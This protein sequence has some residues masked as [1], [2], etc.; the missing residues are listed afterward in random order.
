MNKST[1][2]ALLLLFL[3]ACSFNQAPAFK[4]NDTVMEGEAAEQF[5]HLYGSYKVVGEMEV[6]FGKVSA[7]KV[8]KENGKPVFRL[9]DKT[10]A[11]GLVISPRKCE[12]KIRPADATRFGVTCGA[13]DSLLGYALNTGVDPLILF[14]NQPGEK[15]R[16][17]NFLSADSTL[18]AR[19]GEY[20]LYVS[21]GH[22]HAQL[23]MNRVEPANPGNLSQ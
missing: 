1:T 12:A 10:G 18:V 14:N 21:Y 19:D 16:L 9:Y 17:Q 2:A 8:S 22:S 11:E 4:R 6:S 7:V 3:S 23:V 20:S 5:E 13:H 15:M